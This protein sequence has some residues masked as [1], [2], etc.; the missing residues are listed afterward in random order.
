MLMSS[1]QPSNV[2][3][4]TIKSKSEVFNYTVKWRDNHIEHF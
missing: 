4:Y 2:R 1:K 3:T